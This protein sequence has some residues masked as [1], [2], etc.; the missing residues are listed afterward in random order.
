MLKNPSL[1]LGWLGRWV[2][3]RKVKLL[4]LFKFQLS[5]YLLDFPLFLHFLSTG[6]DEFANEN[7]VAVVPSVI[8]LRHLLHFPFC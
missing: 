2:N 5:F 7:I 4:L 6:T 3:T 8:A 1:L